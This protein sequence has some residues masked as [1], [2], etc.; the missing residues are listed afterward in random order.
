MLEHDLDRLLDRLETY[1]ESPRE[2]APNFWHRLAEELTAAALTADAAA[3]LRGRLRLDALLASDLRARGPLLYGLCLG[4]RPQ[5]RPLTELPSQDVHSPPRIARPPWVDGTLA[6]QIFLWA[7]YDLEAGGSDSGYTYSVRR[8]RGPLPFNALVLECANPDDAD[9]VRELAEAVRRRGQDERRAWHGVVVVPDLPLA[10]PE[11]REG[12]LSEP[13]IAGRLAL[14]QGMSVVRRRPALG[15]L[16]DGR[17]ARQVAIDQFRIDNLNRTYIERRVVSVTGHAADPSTDR[18]TDLPPMLAE[19]LHGDGS[20]LFVV[21]GDFGS[22]KTSFCRRWA[23][24]CADPKQA[25]DR[26]SEPRLPVH[27]DLRRHPSWH[28]S[29]AESLA[30]HLRTHGVWVGHADSVMQLNREGRLLIFLDGFEQIVGDLGPEERAAV[31]GRLLTLTEGRGKL[32]L[33][34]HSRCFP[35]D[36]SMDPHLADEPAWR[37]A[38]TVH[39]RDLGRDQVAE[40]LRRIDPE[41]QEEWLGLLHQTLHLDHLAARPFILRMLVTALPRLA[42]G[43]NGA[44]MNGLYEAYCRPWLSEGDGELREQSVSHLAR[45]LWDTDSERMNLQPD[46]ARVDGISLDADQLA[47]AP[48]LTRDGDGRVGFIHRSVLSFFLARGIAR[49][50]GSQ[51]PQCLDLRR[52]HT[53]VAFFLEQVPEV[54]DLRRFATGI[55]SLPFQPRISDNAFWLLVLHARARLGPLLGP[56]SDDATARQV[57]EI[58]PIF[59]ALR[60]AGLRLS[61]ADLAHCD[62]RG[63]DL[64]AAELRNARLDGADLQLCLLDGAD[65][66]S[67]SLRSADLRRAQL[68]GATLEEADLRGADLRQAGLRL[69]RCARAD[70]TGAR[71]DG[72]ETSGAGF[73]ATRGLPHELMT[74]VTDLRA[75][76]QSGH[77]WRVTDVCW[78]PELPLIAS[79]GEDGVALVWNAAGDRVLRRLVGHGQGANTVAWD[80]RGRRLATGSQD[81]SVII[82]DAETPAIQHRLEGHQGGV[83]DLCWAAD[84]RRLASASDD[85]TVRVWDAETGRCLG[86]LEGHSDA[87]NAVAWDGVT[88]TLASGSDDW[89]VR[90]WRADGTHVTTLAGHSDAVHSLDWSPAGRLLASGS[91]DWTVRLWDSESGA[92]VRT[93]SGHSEGVHAVAWH[94][95][96]RRL[97]SGAFDRLILVWDAETGR[98]LESLSGHSG[99]VRALDWSP[100][101]HRL[102]SGA[103]SQAIRLWDVETQQSTRRL[104]GFAGWIN[105]VDWSPDH[106]FLASGSSGRLV[107]V[108]DR[109]SG[110]S[111]PLEGHTD[112]VHTVAWCPSGRRLASGSNDRT[113]RLW[114]PERGELE[115]VLEGHSGWIRAVHW[116]PDGDRLASGSD[117]RTARLWRAADG[118]CTHVLEGHSGWIRAVA[119]SPDGKTLATGAD[120]GTVKLW[121]TEDGSLEQT[122]GGHGAWVLAIAWHPDRR[123]L[124]AAGADGRVLLWDTAVG[125]RITGRRHLGEE[126]QGGWIH[127]LCWSPDG[128]W[129]LSASVDGAVRVTADPGAHGPGST[130]LEPSHT[131]VLQTGFTWHAAWAGELLAL[132]S[133]DGRVGLWHLHSPTEAARPLVDLWGLPEGGVAVTPDPYV[134]GDAAALE[135]LRLVDSG[136]AVYTLDEVPNRRSRS[137]IIAALNPPSTDR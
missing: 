7:G 132:A 33:T 64:A 18:E 119:W 5:L 101:G 38:R 53:E 98:T 95:D 106:R 39:L 69:S 41:R 13:S 126:R 120:D 22:G 134:D 11:Q 59:Q 130:L 2:P 17:R 103:S 45:A 40:Y 128:R 114:R 55:L 46:Q 54:A 118:V 56:G 9:S 90:L 32:V 133:P 116:S 3:L 12:D 104:G 25:D 58:G 73:L 93:L 43:D 52:V 125:R 136:W 117:D 85:H 81:R 4:L 91:D 99:W 26:R 70:F 78:H 89:T 88:D 19:W 79:A 42:Q 30:E 115:R 1:C 82:W 124:A 68:D 28:R 49:G 100:S 50:I 137:R 10:D 71:L 35:T 57:S 108:W 27:V 31:L 48:F 63:L 127:T 65:L 47:T 121:R 86:V 67:A 15:S 51:D 97:A 16:I 60:P 102:A 66:T 8:E 94:P 110:G 87:V 122:L 131:P 123:R 6:G 111:T 129:L 72:A 77:T 75:V 96:G 105:A 113:V 112:R 84:G 24:H 29:P 36:G 74:T 34:S 61:G 23:A 80:P 135:S 83:T 92:D 107:R 44:V 76:L 21:L 37:S 14:E 20:S 62:L 109:R